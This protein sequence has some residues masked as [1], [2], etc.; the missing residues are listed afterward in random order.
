MLDQCL[1]TSLPP[2]LLSWLETSNKF[3][4]DFLQISLHHKLISVEN[5]KV[6]QNGPM[7]WNIVAFSALNKIMHSTQVVHKLQ[8][9][10]EGSKALSYIVIARLQPEA[11][12]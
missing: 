7:A 5:W 8:N 9:T 2:L 12:L 10:I 1:G 3:Y 6:P 11:T 4:A